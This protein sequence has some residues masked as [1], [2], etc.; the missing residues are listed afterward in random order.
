M[1]LLHTL[2]EDA[3]LR[4]HALTERQ[5]VL[6]LPPTDSVLQRHYAQ[7][8]AMQG[9]A[10]TVTASAPVAPATQPEASAAA[11]PISASVRPAHSPAAPAQPSGGG[12][13]FGWLKRLLG[14]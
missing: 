10:A 12:G 13:L 4:R 2:P 9:S 14:A 11:K 6:G 3:V 1:V 5:R 7:L 8:Q